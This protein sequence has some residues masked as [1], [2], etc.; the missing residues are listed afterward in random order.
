MDVPSEMPA[1][2]ACAVQE[3]AYNREGDCH[4]LAITVGDSRHP[5]CDTF[6]GTGPEG[7]EPGATGR[8]G[9]CKMAD[10]RHNNRLECHAP[11]ITVGYRQSEVDCLTYSP[12]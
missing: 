6:L 5:H 9:A 4:A 12:A 11:G 7:G 2:N 8:V 3:C 1:V 10:C